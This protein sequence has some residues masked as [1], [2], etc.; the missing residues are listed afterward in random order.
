MDDEGSSSYGL[1][2]LFLHCLSY[3]IVPRL[4]SFVALNSPTY[5]VTSSHST[6]SLL[7]Y[8]PPLPTRNLAWELAWANEELANVISSLSSTSTSG[9]GCRAFASDDSD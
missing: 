2:P 1:P 9:I 4:T 7:H 8:P 3:R 5:V 6:S